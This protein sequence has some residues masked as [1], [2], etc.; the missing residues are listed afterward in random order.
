MRRVPFQELLWVFHY[1]GFLFSLYLCPG[2]K[3][4]DGF[5]CHRVKGL[6]YAY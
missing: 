3:D 2:G 1:N 5:L 4:P 6:V